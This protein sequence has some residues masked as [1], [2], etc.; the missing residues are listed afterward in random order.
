M[1]LA[2]RSRRKCGSASRALPALIVS[3]T[4]QTELKTRCAALGAARFTGKPFRD[5]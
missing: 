4:S 2:F 5:R 1:E 3:A